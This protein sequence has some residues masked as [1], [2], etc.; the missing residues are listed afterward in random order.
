MTS[1]RR[2]YGRSAYHN[3]KQKPPYIVSTPVASAH[4]SESHDRS[5]MYEPVALQAPFMRSDLL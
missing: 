4:C 3:S 1:L 2:R 5:I